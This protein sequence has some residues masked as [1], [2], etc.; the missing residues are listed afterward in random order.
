MIDL[1]GSD[2]DQVPAFDPKKDYWKELTSEGGKFYDP[3]PE[4]AKQ[5]LA[6]GKIHAD[7][8]IVTKNKA[9]DDISVDYLR[10]R[11][12]YN[13]RPKIEEMLDQLS[14]K[15]TS[16]E[17]TQANESKDQAQF[18][19]KQVQ[20]LIS[21]KLQDGFV[22][23]EVNKKQ[24]EN[25]NLVSEKLIERHGKNYQ[26]VVKQQIDELGVSLD[27]FNTLAKTNPK[28][29]IKTLG[30]DEPVIPAGFQAPPRSS[31][32]SDSFTPK[33]G[34]KRT[35]SYYQKLKQEKPSNYL[36]QK[37]QT[38]MGRDYLALGKEFEDGDFH[39]HF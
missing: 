4:V 13:K 34:E 27:L 33:G 16:S 3:D 31:V 1:L 25:Q 17:Q 38:Q 2:T 7:N 19:P 39:R 6:F 30:L 22:Q 21:A 15:L 11:E 29:L 24:Q 36:D 23:Y 28:L 26:D 20:D 18:D 10:L 35:W 9:F 14:N 8:F 32:R 37:T 12:D 5:K